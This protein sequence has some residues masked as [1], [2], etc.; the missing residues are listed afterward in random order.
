MDAVKNN[1]LQPEQAPAYQCHWVGWWATGARS[2]AD[3]TKVHEVTA[4]MSASEKAH[5]TAGLGSG[6]TTTRPNSHRRLRLLGRVVVP[7]LPGPTVIL[8]LRPGNVEGNGSSVVAMNVSLLW[9]SLQPVRR[10]GEVRPWLPRPSPTPTRAP[11]TVAAMFSAS[12]L[13]SGVLPSAQRFGPLHTFRPARWQHL[14]GPVRR[15]RSLH[16][17]DK[18]ALAH[19]HVIKTFLA[20]CC[21]CRRRNLHPQPTVLRHKIEFD[22]AERPQSFHDVVQHHVVDRLGGLPPDDHQDFA[23]VR[24]RQWRLHISLQDTRRHGRRRGHRRTSHW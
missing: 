12:R 23:V 13:C 17:C 21:L 16:A 14:W 15:G 11:V 5:V 9:H 7:P 19:G 22:S 2:S 18:G 10:F 20:A 8:V 6:G 1:R 3:T 24:R 4:T